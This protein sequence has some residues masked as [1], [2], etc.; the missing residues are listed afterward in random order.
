MSG[1]VQCLRN[2][3]NCSYVVILETASSRGSRESSSKSRPAGSV[4][5]DGT[6][7]SDVGMGVF[8]PSF[9]KSCVICKKR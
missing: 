3:F 8:D 7:E 1:Q 4:D 5:N 9:V 6:T 2:S